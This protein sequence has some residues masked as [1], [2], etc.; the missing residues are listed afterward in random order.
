VR[1]LPFIA[2]KNPGMTLSDVMLTGAFEVYVS[3][4]FCAAVYRGVPGRFSLFY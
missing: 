2:G 4:G 1:A 3:S